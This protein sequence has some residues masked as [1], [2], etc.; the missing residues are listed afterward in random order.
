MTKESVNDKEAAIIA[1]EFYRSLETNLSVKASFLEAKAKFLST[2]IGFDVEEE[3]DKE[4]Q[5][6][7]WT[8]KMSDKKHE[9]SL[10]GQTQ[11][12][13]K[14]ITKNY[15][16]RI[17]SVFILFFVLWLASWYGP[18]FVER[19]K[20]PVVKDVVQE[21][22]LA[23]SIPLESITNHK[24]DLPV[25]IPHILISG[26][27]QDSLTGIALKGLKIQARSKGIYYTDET[28]ENGFYS[29]SFPQFSS[30]INVRISVRDP[31]GFYGEKIIMEEKQ[32]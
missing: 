14:S 30:A 1:I 9:W 6:F 8:L 32:D 19:A 25:T 11:T 20:K 17:A 31:Q 28:D 13:V 26:I 15:V 27:V 10:Y 23:K 12:Q 22:S 2:E 5:D 21:D 4:F 3:S 7:P 24:Q 16:N 18:L 29:F